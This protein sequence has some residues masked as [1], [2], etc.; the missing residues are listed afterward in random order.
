MSL[1]VPLHAYLHVTHVVDLDDFPIEPDRD[2]WERRIVDTVER[3]TDGGVHH[4][5]IAARELELLLP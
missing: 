1:A 2:D 5:R 4:A 3:E